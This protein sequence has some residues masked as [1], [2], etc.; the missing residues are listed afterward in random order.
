MGYMV[1][2]SSIRQPEL[3]SDAL[4]I[5]A[6]RGGS[7]NSAPCDTAVCLLEVGTR[8]VFLSPALSPPVFESRKPI[9][10]TDS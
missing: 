5:L 2:L 8:S 4:E 6:A 3:D 10:T 9:D 7:K 1:P